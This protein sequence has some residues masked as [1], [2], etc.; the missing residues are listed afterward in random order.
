MQPI[1]S[2]IVAVSQHQSPLWIGVIM[3]YLLYPEVL[4]LTWLYLVMPGYARVFEAVF[5]YL[6]GSGRLFALLG[7]WSTTGNEQSILMRNTRYS[8]SSNTLH[9]ASASWWPRV[10]QTPSV[11]EFGVG[12]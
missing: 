2:V 7:H 5:E 4:N 9:R 1:G 11:R 8:S 12:L 10:G 3:G 6:G